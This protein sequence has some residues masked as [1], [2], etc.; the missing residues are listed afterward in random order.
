MV[1]TLAHIPAAI[2]ALVLVA[3]CVAVYYPALSNG[4]VWDDTIFLVHSSAY[5]GRNR[6]FASLFEPFAL[7]N[8]YYRPLVAL[9]FALVPSTGQFSEVAHH[10]INLLIH[11]SNVVLVYFCSR[12]L[13]KHTVGAFGDHAT[14]YVWCL[15]AAIV[16]SVHPLVFE[17]VLW[18][19]GRF[20]LALTFFCLLFVYLDLR[21]FA[22]ALVKTVLLCAVY[23][24]AAAS[25]ESAVSLPLVMLVVHTFLWT[26][27]SKE[28]N[29]PK[30]IWKQRYTYIA[31]FL[32]GIVY[33]LLRTYAMGQ[34]NADRE[35]LKFSGSFS[36]RLLL[37]SLALFKY[38]QIVLLSW[39]S[40]APLHPYDLASVGVVPRMLI[41]V[42]TALVLA[43]IAWAALGLRQRW[44]YPVL[45]FIVM[46]C[47][48][49]HLVSFSA[50][51]NL[52]A[53][54]YALAPLAFLLIVAAPV[55]ATGLKTLSISKSFAFALVLVACVIL[56]SW[57]AMA[58]ITTKVWR[59]DISLWT[60]AYSLAPHSDMASSNYM[61]ALLRLGK[62][63]EAEVIAISIQNSGRSSMAP[64]TNR[65]LIRAARGDF[66]AAYEI[67]RAVDVHKTVGLSSNDLATYYCTFAQVDQLRRDWPAALKASS[68]ALRY[69]PQLVSC[70][71]IRARALYGVGAKTEA[72]ALLAELKPTVAS[73]RQVEIEQLVRSWQSNE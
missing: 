46:I 53:D 9:S 7:F 55:C 20:D 57:I 31:M 3:F 66:D 12:M 2:V 65:A 25:K 1:R 59:D 5:S 38:G 68:E 58:R 26:F 13:I 54:R 51:T 21:Q 32:A 17:P 71:L 40:T 37:A 10:A 43:S 18:V 27:G 61:S 52:V 8:A 11:A 47:P 4:Y 45:V 56:L 34:L 42:L 41:P 60:Y 49:L 35:I 33:L 63:D 23:L 14:Q 24:F 29:W 39:T 6:F 73:A 19:S 16:F 70:K 28:E 62:L 50:T 67:L 44:A 22:N 36:D 72:L 69:D 64:L 48:V 15:G 30:F